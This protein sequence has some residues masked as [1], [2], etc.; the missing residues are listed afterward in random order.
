M[1]RSGSGVEARATSIRITFTFEGI[2]RKET[3]RTNGEPM[4]PTPANLKFAH[5]LAAEIRQKI[6]FGTFTYA[7]YFPASATAS[8]GQGVTVGDRL[9]LWLGLQSTKEPSTLK[10]YRVAVA[11]WK[12]KIGHKAVRAL[13]HSD[14]LAA[15]ASE[16]EWTGKTRNNKS[17]VLRGAMLLA[18]RDGVISANPI[19]GLESSPHQRPEPDPFTV[20][21]AEAIIKDLRD[22][23]DPQVA[24]YFGFKF[25]TGLRTSESLPLRWDSVDWRRGTIAVSEAVVLGLHKANTKTNVVRQ[26]ELNSRALAFLREQKASTF[27]LAHGLI[28][29][30]PKTG[31]RW[32]DDWTPREMYWRPCLK[33]LGIRYRSPYQ[34]R[35]TYATMLLMAGVTPA[36]A[37]RQMG[38]SVETFLRKYARWIDS[39]ENQR[40]VGKLEQFLGGGVAS[41]RETAG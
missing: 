5:R 6:K 11:W 9:D 19:E 35:H 14:I 38:H 20:D 2:P 30:D 8:T 28:F 7:D 37:A 12:S 22:R 23:A 15:L 32:V 1:G 4:P 26:I 18:L 13:V 21:E 3:L 39:G 34:T 24:R 40:E 25:F 16:P 29:P 36:F 10:G 33:R 27:L 31:E 41:K 17:S